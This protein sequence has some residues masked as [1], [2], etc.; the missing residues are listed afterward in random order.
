MAVTTS[1]SATIRGISYTA[2]QA[3]KC[4]SAQNGNSKSEGASGTSAMKLTAGTTYYFLKA[5]SGSAVTHPYLVGTS[6]SSSSVIGWYKEA[7]FPYATFT[8]SYNANGGSGTMSSHTAT[9]GSSFTVKNNAF[10]RAGYTFA[11]WTT[12]SDGSA[13]GYGWSTSTNAGWSGTWTYKNGQYGIA[14]NKLVLYARWTINTYNA[15]IRHYKRNATDTAWTHFASTDKTA[16]YGSTVTPAATTVP[17]GYYFSHYNSWHE[18]YGTN[19]GA[20]S[21]T[22][23]ATNTIT[24]VYYYPN[25]YY[26]D[27]NGSLDGTSTSGVS[28]MGT[29]DVYV[30]GSLVA[31]NVTDWYTQYNYGSTYEIKDIKTNAGYTYTGS[32]SYS[33]TISGATGVRPTWTSN[34]VQIAY[35]PNGGSYGNGASLNQYG[36]LVKNGTVWHH[37]GLHGGSLTLY[38]AA[39]FG[40]TK[41]GYT[42]AGWTLDYTGE[43]LTGGASYAVS[44]LVDRSGKNTSNQSWTGCYVTANW[45]QNAYKLTVK[46]NW[47]AFNGS[48]SNQE[49]TQAYGTSKSLAVPTKTGRSFIAWAEQG[50][51]TIANALRSNGSFDGGS[52]GVYVYN[53]SS[54]GVVSHSIQSATSGNPIGS[55]YELK[56]SHSGGTSSPGLG[57]FFDSN[58]AAAGKKWVHAFIAKIPVGY[59][60]QIAHNAIGT[61]SS[62]YWLTERV[63]TGEWEEYSY[64]IQCGSSGSFS[65]FGH[66]YLTGPTG[67]FTWY[68]A[69]SNMYDITS[70]V[71]AVNYNYLSGNG[72]V[73][74]MYYPNTY[75]IS[76]NDGLNL[77]YGLENCGLTSSTYINYSINNGVVTATN[78]RGAADGYGYTTGR[79]YLEA[80]KTY[81]F[82]CQTSGTWTGQTEAFLMLNGSTSTRYYHMGNKTGYTFTCDTTGTYW[83]RLD[84]NV[85]GETHT[86]SNIRIYEGSVNHN[87][88]GFTP[89]TSHKYENVIRDTNTYNATTNEFL[90]TGHDLAPYVN[91]KG[92]GWYYIEFECYTDV[93]G[94]VQAYFQNGSGA[95]HAFYAG[96]GTTTSWK[97]YSAIVWVSDQGSSETKSMLA[98]YSVYGTGAKPHVRNIVF[99]K[100]N[101]TAA[102]NAFTRPNYKFI[103]WNTKRDGS[104]LSIIEN[105]A[106]KSLNSGTN[107][108]LYAQWELDICNI[109]YNGNG[110]IVSNV[111]A[112]QQKTIGTNIALSSTKPARGDRYKFLGWAE[113]SSAT[114]AAYQPGATFTKDVDTTLYAVWQ[115]LDKDIYLYNT[116]K[117]D[118]VDFKTVSAVTD[119]FDKNGNVYATQFVTH[120]ES[121]IYIGK[122]GKIYAK[123]FIKY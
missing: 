5:A 106:L 101:E 8:V 56:I 60:L 50:S 46:P 22:M 116:G 98:F 36:Y 84:I 6:S 16:T 79:V 121:N 74:A 44:K 63:G 51:G 12:K 100:C 86:F 52:N 123:E 70:G 112:T 38:T 69:Y 13:D 32:A 85:N 26:L 103:G 48:Q 89:T 122:D 104:G 2:G 37:N 97:K 78:T 53:N 68:V 80:G 95:K 54:N 119:L 120:S 65:T 66:V 114:S 105:G 40:L 31:D 64:V 19:L 90:Q 35:H 57:G 76:Y 117:I 82:S 67:A 4:Y 23:P 94:T 49:F 71:G 34:N 15:Y 14:N 7:V 110:N 88:T 28:P 96:F 17:T 93:A 81:T 91:R 58:T 47:G 92:I 113:S 118:A 24:E 75:N 73:Y 30:N 87:I 9:Y 3:F 39:D 43:V 99:A 72:S 11:G 111:P 1:N 42:F 18:G 27:L 115:L 102:A 21:F 109:S 62:E 20:S 83:L 107:L 55:G 29:A 33:G 108:T 45:T 59:T 10:T 25:K 61:G 77:L 41:P